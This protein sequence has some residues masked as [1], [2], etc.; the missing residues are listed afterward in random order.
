MAPFSST[1]IVHKMRKAEAKT[2]C[3]NFLLKIGRQIKSRLGLEG[4]WCYWGLNRNFVNLQISSPGSVGPGGTLAFG[5]C[6]FCLAERDDV[7][8]GL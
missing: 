7:D 4:E 8:L 2:H 6:V 5:L 3:F 1:D